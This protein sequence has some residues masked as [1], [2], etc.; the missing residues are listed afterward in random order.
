M[1]LEDVM[2]ELEA[3]GSAQTVKTFRNHGAHGE[4]YGV[5]VGDLKPI[6][7][8][9]KK[10]QELAMQLW[11]T[12]NSD[13]MYLASLIADGSR[14][15]IQQLNH[16]AKTASWYMLSEYTVPFVAAEHVQTVSLATNWI[17]AMDRVGK[18]RKTARC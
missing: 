18:K 10:R 6:A 5:K 3:L 9:W 2:N 4:L 14:M 7:K 15:T 16:W 13:A 8:R 1:N 12:N 11:D 17:G